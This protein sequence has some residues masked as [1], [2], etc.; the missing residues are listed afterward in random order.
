MI[1][2]V[3]VLFKMCQFS[4]FTLKGPSMQIFFFFFFNIYLFIFDCV[5][6]S[7]L[8]EG[9]PQLQRA[10]VTLHCGAQVSHCCG[11]SCCGAQAPDVQVQQLWL[12]GLVAPWNVGSS[13]TRART[14]VPCIGRQILNH[15][16]TREAP[17]MQILKQTKIKERRLAL[18]SS[19]FSIM[20]SFNSNYN[21]I[22]LVQG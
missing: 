16:T 3:T 11:L 2:I 14:R 19:R 6:S 18:V 1:M 4:K 20:L 8:C 15:C 13:H 22:M 12:M 21:R 5:G 17:S 10:G 9:F 7:F